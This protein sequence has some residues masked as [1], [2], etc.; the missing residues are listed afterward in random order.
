[1]H[2]V[3]GIKEITSSIPED[4]YVIPPLE[5]ETKPTTFD[6]SVI[7]A[8]EKLMSSEIDEG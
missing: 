5:T 4:N 1:L 7:D 6:G 2:R 3:H 8:L